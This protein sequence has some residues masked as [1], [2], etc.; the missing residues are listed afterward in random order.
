MMRHA[1]SDLRPYV[2]IVE[3]CDADPMDFASRAEF[4][5]HLASHQH[6]WLW[7]CKKCDFA[8]E[9]QQLV[10]EHI[11]LAHT[12]SE[13]SDEVDISKKILRDISIQQCPFC[14]EIPGAVSFVGH[15]CHHL[16]EVSLAAL[17]QAE[18]EEDDQ[19]G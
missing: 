2:C 8:E 5:V 18:L 4:A 19:G 1:Y 15:I 3:G 7:T 17:P 11:Y 12:L 14:R 10:E 16:E 9:N 13:E 6:I